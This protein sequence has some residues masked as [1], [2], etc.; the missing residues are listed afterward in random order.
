[1]YFLR[2]LTPKLLNLAKKF[3][4]V[5]VCGPR[6]SGKTTLIQ[7]AFPNLP[8]VNL[9]QTKERDFASEDPTGFLQRFPQGAILDEIQR[10]PQ[11]LSDLQVVVDKNKKMGEFII[12]GSQQFSLLESISQSL[13]GRTSILRLLPLS[14]FELKQAN[15]FDP[16]KIDALMLSGFYPGRWQRQISAEDFFGAYEESY[17]ERDLKQLLNVKDLAQFRK[18]LKLCA[19]RTANLLNKDSLARDVG[20]SPKTVEQWI[21]IL[22]TSFIAFR[23]QP[24]FKNQGKRLIKSPKL[25]FYDVGLVCYLLGIYEV[26][27]LQNHPLRGDI[28]ENLAVVETLKAFANLGLKRDLYFYRN[29]QGQEID[30]VIEAGLNVLPLEIKSSQTFAAHFTETLKKIEFTGC[31][32]PWGKWL[33]LSSLE[34][35]QRSETQIVPWDSLGEKIFGIF[36]SKES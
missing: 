15:L 30:L 4:I 34:S 19:G 25:Y 3:P 14:I 10:V 26:S 11:L 13:A 23:L 31:D 36:A 17:V 9:E 32:H 27:H 18:F 28:F 7:K 5:T 16:Q 22:E 20:I 35:Y 21:S 8:Y 12:S 33:V 24:W 6:Q 2:D 1:M 29:S